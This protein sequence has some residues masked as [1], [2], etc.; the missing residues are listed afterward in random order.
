MLSLSAFRRVVGA[1]MSVSE[2]DA[3]SWWMAGA[4]EHSLLRRQILLPSQSSRLSFIMASTSAS[5]SRPDVVKLWRQTVVRQLI[6]SQLPSV[7]NTQRILINI[8]WSISILQYNTKQ[9]WN[10]GSCHDHDEFTHEVQ[11]K[12]Q[13]RKTRL[14]RQ[15]TLWSI[16][17]D[18]RHNK[19]T[20]CR[21][22]VARALVQS[23]FGSRSFKASD[24]D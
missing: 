17:N 16:I 2:R 19:N 8:P 10:S 11:F 24:N 5:A 22:R 9:Q 18:L 1:V 15:I 12:W 20:N 4:S 6:S 14:L 7:S 21:K 23:V 13:F 3:V